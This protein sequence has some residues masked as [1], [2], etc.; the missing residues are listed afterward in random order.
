M[1]RIKHRLFNNMKTQLRE[2][3]LAKRNALS[4]ERRTAL[5]KT[6]IQNVIALPAYQHA[7]ILFCY[8]HFGS[9]VM[10]TNLIAHALQNGK[11]VAL[12]RVERK[13][14]MQFYRYD[15]TISLIKNRF[16]IDEPDVQKTQKIT[17]QKNSFMIVPGVVFDQHNYRIGYGKGF[18]DRYLAQFPALQTCGIAFS[19]QNIDEIPHEKH[20]KALNWVITENAIRVKT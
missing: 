1:M 18:Y 8:L 10:T 13:N 7:D 3:I 16:G 11:C 9:E 4:L 5:S 20:D 2:H 19:C 12:P 6:I 14:H 15:E 17:P